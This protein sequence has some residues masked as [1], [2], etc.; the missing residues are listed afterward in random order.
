MTKKKGIFDVAIDIDVLKPKEVAPE[1][2][3]MTTE[4]A[5]EIVALQMELNGYRDVH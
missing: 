2:K 5:L 3:G 1:P 4:N